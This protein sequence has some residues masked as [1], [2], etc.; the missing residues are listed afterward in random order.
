MINF[1]QVRLIGSTSNRDAI[2]A[3]IALTAGGKT[4]HRM[5]DGKSGYLAHSVMPVYFGLGD[6]P[7]IN[8]I[9]VTWPS[10]K[11]QSITENL[12]ANR[13]LTINEPAE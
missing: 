2:G 7:Q 4:Q 8:R 13:L 1:V 5:L 11:T 3:R 12:S 9:E 10:G 6:N